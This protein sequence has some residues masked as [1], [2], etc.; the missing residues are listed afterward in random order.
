MKFPKKKYSIIYADP[1]WS[2]NDK[3]L[4]GK[5]GAGCHYPVQSQKWIESLPVNS[6]A[7][8]NCFLFLWVTFPKIFEI[9]PL[10]SAWGFKYKTCAFTWIKRNKKSGSLFW[11]MG[12]WTRANA[13]L[14]LLG[15]RGAPERRSAGVHQVIESPIGRHSEKPAE[16]RERI[17]KLCGDLPRIELFA[18]QS[19]PGWDVWGNDLNIGDK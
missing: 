8:E 11:G 14:C 9:A 12:N 18:R 3:A 15:V 5:R 13:E 19:T 1:P 17:V 10:F 2:Y 16:A 7:A 6:I 4:A